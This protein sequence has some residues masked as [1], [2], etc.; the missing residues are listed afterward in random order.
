MNFIKYIFCCCRTC[1]KMS[2]FLN[3][4]LFILILDIFSS[5]KISLI[6]KR[7]VDKMFTEQIDFLCNF[8]KANSK[9]IDFSIFIK[10]SIT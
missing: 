6:S 10:C 8:H 5:S 3:M 2:Y 7:V 4:L 1:I 9:L